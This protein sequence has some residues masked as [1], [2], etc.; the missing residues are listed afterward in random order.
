MVAELGPSAS[1]A[2]PVQKG[3]R[4]PGFNAIPGQTPPSAAVIKYFARLWTSP[5]VRMAFLRQKAAV[6]SSQVCYKVLPA[7]ASVLACRD[8]INAGQIIT[9]AAAAAAGTP[10]TE[11]VAVIKETYWLSILVTIALAESVV[12][13]EEM[14]RKLVSVGVKT[15][16]DCIIASVRAS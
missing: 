13:I 6:I 1:I 16:I 15:T 12:V 4:V 7:A 2:V 3:L 9:P 8:T 14:S 10:L 5:A 11:G